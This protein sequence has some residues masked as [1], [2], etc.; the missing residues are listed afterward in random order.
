MKVYLL[1]DQLGWNAENHAKALL[2]YTPRG[3]VVES[4]LW[5]PT[6]CN[7]GFDDAD[8]IVNLGSQCQQALWDQ[9]QERIPRAVVLARYYTCY[10]RN[11][12]RMDFLRARSHAVIVESQLCFQRTEW[13][14]DIQLT[15]TGIDCRRFCPLVPPLKR[16]RRVLWVAGVVGSNAARADVKRLDLA[17]EV[18]RRCF[19]AGI[20][21]EILNVDPHGERKTS[22]EMAQWYNSGN[23]YLCTSES[24]G[25]PNTGLEAMACGCLAVSTPV[26][27]MP[28]VIE[29]GRNGFIVKP[30]AN[31]I[32]ETIQRAMREWL[33]RAADCYHTLN[34]RARIVQS[35]WSKL[36]PE[37]YRAVEALM[38]WKRT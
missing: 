4:V 24:E 38:D 33:W 29:H 30:D 2:D 9:S 6:S 3:W 37:F 13:M 31:E 32:V 8:A 36:A 23:V 20:D 27:R 10:P 7:W 11:A 22:D 21:M 12:E 14:G 25:V 17:K 19:E 34:P 5:N 15:P 35:D 1:L 16:R 26:G 18:G 28:E